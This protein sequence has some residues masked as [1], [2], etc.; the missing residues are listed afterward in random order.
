MTG[1]SAGCVC[2]LH[3]IMSEYWRS[4]QE[5]GNSNVSGR[6]PSQQFSPSN[7]VRS[8]EV[9]LS[10]NLV[11]LILLSP[12]LCS[13]WGS[14]SLLNSSCNRYNSKLLYVQ[15]R[16]C[17]R[18]LFNPRSLLDEATEAERLHDTT[19]IPHLVRGRVGSELK[20]VD[21]QC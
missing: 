2:S 7:T 10:T 12:P 15:N 16:F 9:P 5:K 11:S 1:L 3:L 20:S 21:V 19:E 14:H 13:C 8:S 18:G 6:H 17:I 4:V